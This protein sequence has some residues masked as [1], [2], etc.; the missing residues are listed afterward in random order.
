MARRMK[1]VAIFA[2]LLVLASAAL[3]LSAPL[4]DAASGRPRV[5]ATIFPVYDIATNV[6][7]NV[8]DVTLILPPGAEPHSFEPSP[9][10]VREVAAASAVYAVGHGIDG[11]IDPL[12]AATSAA[13]VTVDRG[14]ALLP[15]H[16]AI[17]LS[18]EES[19]EEEGR[20]NV[21]PD[22]PH[23][24]LTVPNAIL[25][26]GTIADDL[27]ARF[28]AHEDEFRSNAAS[29]EVRLRA[30]DAELRATIPDGKRIVTFHAAWYYFADAYG[31]EI[32]GTFEPSPGREPTP[33]ALAELRNLVRRNGIR[34]IFAEPLFSDAAIEAF[35]A[36]EGLTIAH[37]DDIGGTA[38]RATYEELMRSNAKIIAESK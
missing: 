14:I 18:D 34:T 5:A 15:S 1:T 6:A 21:G 38:G 26:A 2:A 7:G 33:R 11:W 3:L 25:I 20:E 35:A 9:S 16:E 22:D 17:R 30:L 10:T 19:E 31:L 28:P 13:P 12:L 23:Y 36:D 27:S 8:A 32:L 29:Y 37:I 24:W 4:R